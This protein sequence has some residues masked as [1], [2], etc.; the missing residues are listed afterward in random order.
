MRSAMRKRGPTKV[1]LNL[2]EQPVKDA[3]DAVDAMWRVELL[4]DAN[5]TAQWR[6]ARNKLH[7]A[8]E[9]IADLLRL[10]RYLVDHAE[11]I[12]D[13]EEPTAPGALRAN[14][15]TTGKAKKV[16]QRSEGGAS[17]SRSGRARR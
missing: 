11:A 8:R 2:I 4:G 16:F 6:T 1:P 15:K 9:R 12:A 10:A 7:E 3:W 14:R 13:Q 17:L 5:L